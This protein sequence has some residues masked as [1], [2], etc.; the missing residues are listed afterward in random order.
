MVGAGAVSDYCRCCG[1]LPDCKIVLHAHGVALAWVI[2]NRIGG[3][4]G[5]NF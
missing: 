1:S 5:I 4:R 2:D 3:L